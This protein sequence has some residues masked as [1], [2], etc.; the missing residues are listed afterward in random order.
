MS[1]NY[2]TTK[3]YYCQISGYALFIVIIIL[4]PDK[5]YF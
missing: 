5:Y 2:L 3:N 4:F 1:D